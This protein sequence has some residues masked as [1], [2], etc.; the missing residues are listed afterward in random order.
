MLL[1]LKI[2]MSSD[3]TRSNA[4]T[5]DILLAVSS[6]IAFSRRLWLT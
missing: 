6:I 5:S 2:R 3:F 4:A 1:S